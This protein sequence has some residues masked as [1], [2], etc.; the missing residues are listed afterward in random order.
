L[1]VE[2]SHR[3]CKYLIVIYMPPFSYGILSSVGRGAVG[4]GTRYG[5]D[6]PGTES[7]W[8]RDFS[9]LPIS[10]LPPPHTL[11]YNGYWVFPVCKAAGA[12]RPPTHI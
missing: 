6:G 7:R 9:H 12:Y 8:G 2:T 10:A 1:H 5:L 4:I 3:C 11:L